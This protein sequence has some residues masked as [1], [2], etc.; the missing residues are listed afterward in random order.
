MMQ[1]PKKGTAFHKVPFIGRREGYKHAFQGI[2]NKNPVVEK[3][4]FK[5]GDLII[6]QFDD[7]GYPGRGFCHITA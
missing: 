3:I 7:L 6:H 1:K 5:S 2:G 4:N